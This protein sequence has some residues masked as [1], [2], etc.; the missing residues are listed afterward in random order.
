LTN[1]LKEHYQKLLDEVETSK[2]QQTKL[3][4]Q[5]HALLEKRLKETDIKLGKAELAGQQARDAATRA[6]SN[7]NRLVRAEQELRQEAEKL[8]AELSKREELTQEGADVLI[9]QISTLVVEKAKAERKKLE[10][11]E[12][13]RKKLEQ[14]EHERKKLEQREH[15]RK[16]L[17]QLKREFQ[18]ARERENQQRRQ[19]EE[20]NATAVM[21]STMALMMASGAPANAV[22]MWHCATPWCSAYW[23]GTHSEMIMVGPRV[24]R[25]CFRYTRFS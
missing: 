8:R 16:K 3:M 23:S 19:N 4:A 17:E 22:Q 13:E 20:A 14:R 18:A 15:E 1:T 9:S 25:S 24:C 11:R 12:H 21:V 10:E 6:N 5:K 2:E 7:A